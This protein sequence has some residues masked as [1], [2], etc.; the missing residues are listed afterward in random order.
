MSRFFLDIKNVRTTAWANE[1]VRKRRRTGNSS[2]QR[3]DPAW[4]IVQHATAD[5]LFQRQ[6]LD[7]MTAVS[8]DEISQQ[9][10]ALLTDRVLL[11]EGKNQIYGTQFVVREGEWVPLRLEDEK[12][13]DARSCGSWF[14]AIGRIQGNA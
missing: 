9:N 1:F 6:S 12:N 5:S 11:A 7:L 13:V 3:C 2:R 10:L 8:K 14:T 4:L